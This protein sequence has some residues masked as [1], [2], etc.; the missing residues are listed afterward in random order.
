MQPKLGTPAGASVSADV[1]AV[2]SDTAAV[3]DDT[4]TSGVVVAAASK[5]GYRLSST[6]VQDI[7]DALTS[8]LTTA[9]SIGKLLVDNINATISSRLA[10]SS[11]TAP[12]DAAG[13]RSAVGLA[14]ANLDTQLTAID[15]YIDT[16]VAAIKA[17]TD[18]IPA[19]PAATSD[20]PSAATI[21]D[22]VW[23][24]A[25][26]GH[27]TAGSG[28]KALADIDGHTDTEIAAIKAKTDSLTFTTAGQVDAQVISVANNALTAAA[29]AG[30]LGT[31]IATAVWTSAT[32]TLSA[33]GFT[34]GA[35]DLAADTI[36]ASELASDAITEIVNA[37]LTTAMTESYNADGA[38]PTL[39]QAMFVT[40]QRLTEFAISGT[41]VTVKKLDGSTTAYTLTLDDATDPTSTTRAT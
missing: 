32:R 4:G 31:E 14:S 36:G 9:S 15:D 12:L 24:E 6:G 3:L 39:A 23:D 30:D 11:Y 35:S 25:L 8:A 34:L 21:A 19:S 1:A 41:T 26:S 5:T 13:T 17:K 20:I 10:S 27:A 7:W 33:L 22:A 38:A 16:E 2:K 29:A 18:L 37:V 40:M 28:G